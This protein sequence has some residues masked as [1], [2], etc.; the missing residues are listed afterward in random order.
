LFDEKIEE[1]WWLKWA[2]LRL[3]F[4]GV[5]EFRERI[6]CPEREFDAY[7]INSNSTDEDLN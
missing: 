6:G 5:K 1:T 7:S 3:Y 4:P 2:R